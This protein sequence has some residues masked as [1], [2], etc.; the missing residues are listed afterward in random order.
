LIRG[1]DMTKAFI[2]EVQERLGEGATEA[3]AQKAARW[4]LDHYD[5]PESNHPEEFF[6]SLGYPN[7]EVTCEDEYDIY[8]A[9]DVWAKMYKE[10]FGVEV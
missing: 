1:F 7:G 4:F 6:K 5:Y 2:D 3:D 10:V 9:N 8:V